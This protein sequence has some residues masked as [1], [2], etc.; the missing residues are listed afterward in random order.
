MT[1]TSSLSDLYGLLTPNSTISTTV[2]TTTTIIAST[3]ASSSSS[4]SSSYLSPSLLPANTHLSSDDDKATLG[5]V[6]ALPPP[7]SSSSSYWPSV[8]PLAIEYQWRV[9][10]PS[11]E[12][13]LRPLAD[14]YHR[15]RH[16]SSS[17]TFYTRQLTAD[18]AIQLI[19][20]F[21]FTAQ[22]FR[23]TMPP[24]PCL[25]LLC[26]QCVCQL[27]HHSPVTV[28]DDSRIVM[29]ISEEST[30]LNMKQ[31]RVDESVR[32]YNR[33]VDE[34]REREEVGAG[35]GWWGWWEEW[36]RQ[37]ERGR[38]TAQAQEIIAKRAALKERDRHLVERRV[39]FE[40]DY[41]ERWKQR[42]AIDRSPSL[43]ARL[44]PDALEQLT[45]LDPHVVSA[46][47]T[48]LALNVTSL[49]LLPRLLTLIG[50]LGLHF[51]I[52]YTDYC[53]LDE[54]TKF[55]VLLFLSPS[56]RTFTG[57]REGPWH[58][59]PV[60]G[61]YAIDSDRRVHVHWT[62]R[63]KMKTGELVVI[64]HSGVWEGETE[65]KG[66]WSQW[67]GEWTIQGMGMRGEWRMTPFFKNDGYLEIIEKSPT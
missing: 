12:S 26:Q 47:V 65:T 6:F 16:Q 39:Q 63:Q 50:G 25:A 49:Y 22:L 1:I 66:E 62:V 41:I 45:R 64:H 32:H 3:P 24:S 2:T 4:P 19:E 40:V 67:K 52:S 15:H 31:L 35:E 60:E 30:E 61:E 21:Q 9:V 8:I 23:A 48:H 57:T 43:I 36:S 27:M 33:A 10:D 18:T 56:H 59:S 55:L 29:E 54:P 7:F 37:W 42:P 13:Q 46:D 20:I 53:V 38:L 11:R 58:S 14:G 28:E 34:L 17:L 5:R 51:N 44:T